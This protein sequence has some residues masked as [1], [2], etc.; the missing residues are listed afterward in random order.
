VYTLINVKGVDGGIAQGIPL[1]LGPK[2]TGVL[3]EVSPGVWVS[4]GKVL[5]KFAAQIKVNF[6]VALS[7]APAISG[8][9][10]TSFMT[11]GTTVLYDVV[12]GPTGVNTYTTGI[13]SGVSGN[14]TPSDSFTL[15][16]VLV[17]SITSFRE[18][19]GGELTSLII[20][21]VYALILTM[22]KSIPVDVS[23]TT[24]EGV[25]VTR[26]SEF[27]LTVPYT[28]SGAAGS[29]TVTLTNAKDMD[30]YISSIPRTINFTT[31]TALPDYYL[32][33]SIENSFTYNTT[34]KLITAISA[35]NTGMTY[36]KIG[37]AWKANTLNGL[38]TIDFLGLDTNI[39]C[40][41]MTAA[42]SAG[43]WT[44][45][46]LVKAADNGGSYTLG[47]SFASGTSRVDRFI[48]GTSFASQIPFTINGGPPAALT[49]T[50]TMGN[51]Y[52]FTT[53]KTGAAGQTEFYLNDQY[54]GGGGQG[55]M[56]DLKY[57]N[58]NGYIPAGGSGSRTSFAEVRLYKS[59]MTAA[60]VSSLYQT[61]RNKWAI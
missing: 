36:Q 17:Q 4:N 53:T 39:A 13:I 18:N 14:T 6:S 21:Q 11:G 7:T 44:I 40:V 46:Y 34:T 10:L 2:I 54:L 45:S 33:A 52:L 35:V 24:F 61:I 12:F 27:T 42:F 49:K 29:R 56:G 25:S 48:A 59:G 30:L 5:Y 57:F 22:M 60:A 9:V 19:S 37:G 38:G 16:T 41:D 31:P 55:A 3:S 51:W 50:I 23:T 26:A 20:G 58:I 47:T 8:C 32:D 1:T 15:E 28:A 43:S